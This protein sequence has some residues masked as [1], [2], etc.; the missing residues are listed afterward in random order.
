[1]ADTWGEQEGLPAAQSALPA[2]NNRSS[3]A[4]V[5]GWCSGSGVWTLFRFDW[6]GKHKESRRVTFF[7]QFWNN[8]K[9]PEKLPKWDKPSYRRFAHIPQS[10]TFAEFPLS[11]SVCVCVFTYVIYAFFLNYLE[12]IMPLYRKIFQHIVPKNKDIQLYN[13]SRILK[14]RTF[15]MNRILFSTLQSGIF[16]ILLISAIMTFTASFLSRSKI[17]SRNTFL[18]CKNMFLAAYLSPFLLHPTRVHNA[19]PSTPQV[20]G[21]SNGEH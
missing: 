12:I 5:P 7:F 18:S 9:L 3:S 19:Q 10:L 14:I 17:Q 8:C 13:H 21:G 4:E 6:W 2:S 16:Q 1:M 15:K 11:P 20:L